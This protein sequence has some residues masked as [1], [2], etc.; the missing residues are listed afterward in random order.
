MTCHKT[1]V[2]FDFDNTLITENSDLYVR[3]LAPNGEI[4]DE[5]TQL[6]SIHGW[7]K[8]MGAI[9]ELLHRNSVTAA[10][11]QQCMEEIELVEGMPELLAYLV[12][13]NSDTIIISD[14]NSVFIEMIMNAA[15]LANTVSKV[16]TNPAEFDSRGCLTVRY[17]HSQD[18][19]DLSTVNLCKGHILESHIKEALDK[20]TV[21][22]MVAYV[23]DGS[24]DI[25]P[26]LKLKRASDM[27]FP[28]V[29]HTMLKK[30][31]KY[32]DSMIAKVVPWE[33]GLDILA[34]LKS[35]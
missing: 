7:T 10:D 8:Y 20:G 25:C 3:K 16:Y 35:P 15:G 5:I 14:A 23:G 6:Y 24:N 12:K 26:A 22:D 18:W 17:Y 29:G 11:I 33:T 4:P 21:Y 27:V 9:F 28:R 19:C 1:L 13:N 2:A 32:K 31:P 30:L 34:A